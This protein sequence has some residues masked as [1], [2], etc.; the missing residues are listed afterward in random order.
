MVTTRRRAKQAAAEEPDAAA[1]PPQSQQPDD[2]AAQSQ[3]KK[4]PWYLWTAPEENFELHPD[5]DDDGIP[6]PYEFYL[7]PAAIIVYLL[8]SVIAGKP[9]WPPVTYDC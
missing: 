4:V 9:P 1:H 5:D 7:I 8:W 3:R 6:T 2:A